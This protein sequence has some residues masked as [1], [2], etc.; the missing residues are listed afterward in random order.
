M[1]KPKDPDQDLIA[2]FVQMAGRY[3]AGGVNDPKFKPI[4]R[5]AL[6]NIPFLNEQIVEASDF[7]NWDAGQFLKAAMDKRGDEY[8]KRSIEKRIHDFIDITEGLSPDDHAQI[9]Q[10]YYRRQKASKDLPDEL[11]TEIE[12]III[13]TQAQGADLYISEEERKPPEERKLW[14]DT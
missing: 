14:R 1:Q 4:V 10:E 9:R 3:L 11:R 7:N 12:D 6:Q 13:H 2:D 5:W 8:H